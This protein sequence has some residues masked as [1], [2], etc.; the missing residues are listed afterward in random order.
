MPRT[1]NL[2]YACYE[3]PNIPLQYHGLRLLCQA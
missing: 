1:E 2:P 3:T